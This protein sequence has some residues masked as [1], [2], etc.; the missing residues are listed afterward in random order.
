[1]AFGVDEFVVIEPSNGADDAVVLDLSLSSGDT[2]VTGQVLVARYG[3]MVVSILVGV[4]GGSPAGVPSV[5]DVVRWA[6]A[7]AA[8]G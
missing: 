2:A 3:D 7:I 8:R 6:D 4:E 5:Y 1:M